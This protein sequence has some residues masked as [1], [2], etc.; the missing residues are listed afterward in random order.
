MYKVVVSKN[1]GRVYFEYE[2]KFDKNQLLSNCISCFP[3]ENIFEL[4]ELIKRINSGEVKNCSYVFEGYYF[5]VD[6][7]NV[8]VRYDEGD[9]VMEENY[10]LNELLSK[11]ITYCDEYEKYFNVDIRK[12]P[13]GFD[14]NRTDFFDEDGIMDYTL[15]ENRSEEKKTR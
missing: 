5:V 12:I 14:F 7:D 3:S 10:T 6:K 4:L 2:N 9:L 11:I 15:I 8:Y 1:M 13:D